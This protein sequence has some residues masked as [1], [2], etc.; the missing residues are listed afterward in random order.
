MYYFISDSSLYLYD[1]CSNSRMRYKL[2]ALFLCVVLVRCSDFEPFEGIKISQY[3][4]KVIRYSSQYQSTSWSA[5]KAI[6]KARDL[7]KIW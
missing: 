5:N 7:F 6:G 3:A 2:A 4:S 1:T